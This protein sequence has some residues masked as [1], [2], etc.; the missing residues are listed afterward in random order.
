MHYNKLSIALFPIPSSLEYLTSSLRKGEKRKEDTTALRA[1]FSF[2]NDR[3][4]YEDRSC[5]R[6]IAWGAR[7]SNAFE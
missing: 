5:L 7:Y 2:K 1:P 6:A 3:E 4:T